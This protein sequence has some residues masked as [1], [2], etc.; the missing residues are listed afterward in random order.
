[1]RV[2]E[3]KRFL[4]EL[5]PYGEALLAQLEVIEFFQVEDEIIR[6]SNCKQA[7]CRDVG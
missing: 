1:M 2:S 6:E 7:V 3:S 5:S 4:D